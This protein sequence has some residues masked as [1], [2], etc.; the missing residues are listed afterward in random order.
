MPPPGSAWP[1][2][3][4]LGPEERARAG[5]VAHIADLLRVGVLARDEDAELRWQSHVMECSFCHEPALELWE[6]VSTTHEPGFLLQGLSCMEVRNAVF[7]Y[8]ERSREM[9]PSVLH[10]LASCATCGEVFVEPTRAL[11]TREVAED[12]ISAQD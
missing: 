11:Y 12:S 6:Q 5:A 8:I 1:S 9:P 10:H 4:D 7:R 3:V 2:Y